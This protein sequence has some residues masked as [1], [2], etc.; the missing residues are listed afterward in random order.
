MC[1]SYCT[2][3]IFCVCFYFSSATCVPH[4]VPQ[5][6]SASVSILAALHVSLILYLKHLL[7][8]LGRLVVGSSPLEVVLILLAVHILVDGLAQDAVFLATH[9][10]VELVDLVL[11]EAETV[12]VGSAAVE[13]VGSSILG[14]SQTSLVQSIQFLFTNNLQ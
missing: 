7:R 2:S 1:P 5:A 3:S 13:A 9:R 12:A 11:V 10:A 14:L 4:T 6:S 8:L